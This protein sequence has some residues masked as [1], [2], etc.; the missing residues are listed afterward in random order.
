MTTSRI[1]YN[2]NL[3]TIN[4]HLR[5]GSVI[6]TDAPNDNEGL[7]EDFSPTD[8]TAT[9]LGACMLTVMGIKANRKGWD[10]DGSTCDVKKVMAESPRRISAIIVSIKMPA[11]LDDEQRKILER[12]A[13]T[14]PVAK[15]L[16]ERV[17]QVVEFEYA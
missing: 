3:R 10:I 6:R 9:S 7:G 2:G 17:E 5:S 16:S 1:T 13:I 8:L 12:V 11:K 14:C 4:E 15:S